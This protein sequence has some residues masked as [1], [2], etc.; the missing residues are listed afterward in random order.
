MQSYYSLCGI[1][2]QSYSPGSSPR[3]ILSAIYTAILHSTTYEVHH[4]KTKGSAKD[5]QGKTGML[6]KILA[7]AESLL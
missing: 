5:N 7:K 4:G 6:P 1:G 2:I 3:I